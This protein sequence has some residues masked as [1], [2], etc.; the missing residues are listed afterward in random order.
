[1]PTNRLT[2]IGLLFA[3]IGAAAAACSVETSTQGARAEISG[4]S[5]GGGSGGTSN[6]GGGSGGSTTP[7]MPEAGFIDPNKP[8]TGGSSPCDPVSDDHDGDGFAIA[9]GD[10]NDCDPNTNPGAFDIAGNGADEDCN[11]A[12]DDTM[13]ACDQHIIDPAYGDPNDAARAI[14][15]CHFTTDAEVTWGVLS[16]QYVKADGTPG[17]NDLAH[18]LLQD[19]GPNVNPQEGT[20]MLVLSSGTARTP[21]MLGYQPVSGAKMGTTSQTPPG[22]PV[23]SPSC[24]VTTANDTNAN[25]PAALEVKIRVPTNANGFSYNLNFYTFEYPGYICTQYNDFFVALQ[26]P[27]PPNSL[28]GNISFDSQGNPISVNS[29]F[30]EVCTPGTFGGKTFD[31]MRGTSELQGTGYEPSAATG[32]LVT[33]SPVDAGSIVT[34]RFA[35]WDMGDHILD[36]TVLLDAFEWSAEEPQE[37][38][39]IPIPTPK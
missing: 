25:D 6:G 22:Y 38:G 12:P 19:F 35:I 39:T 31:C 33:T 15:L 4:G 5:G 1:M 18:G 17:M 11:G 10:C 36:S 37:A 30:L 23:D 34:L 24:S 3:A 16:A 14:G 2:S 8:D 7:P 13:T 21:G 20:K 32:W 29:G 27:P 26:D 9:D 28:Q